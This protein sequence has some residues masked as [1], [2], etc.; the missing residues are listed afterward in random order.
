MD[1]GIA[2]TAVVENQA[3]LVSDVS[4]DERF[5]SLV[6]GIGA[7]GV[8]S[9]VACPVASARKNQVVGVLVVANKQKTQRHVNA[10]RS[11]GDEDEDNAEE[12]P[13]FSTGDVAALHDVAM[14]ASIVIDQLYDPHV[15]ED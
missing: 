11:G 8:R 12:Q 1:I 14:L 13:V 15:S 7:N 4:Q 10:H 9:L 2:A 3:Q 5:D 6:D